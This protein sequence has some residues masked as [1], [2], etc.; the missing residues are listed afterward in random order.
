[1]GTL[2][3]EI[4]ERDALVRHIESLQATLTKRNQ[5]IARLRDQLDA[6][7][8]SPL[9]ASAYE[10]G[11]REGWSSCADALMR[12]THEAARSLGKI[13]REAFE[14]YLE[15]ER[16]ARQASSDM[17]SETYSGDAS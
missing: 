2:V 1:M 11:K 8:G 6:G 7:K 13:R 9:I 17:S 12:A 3:I 14:V 16:A 10:R 4:D 5:E 15:G